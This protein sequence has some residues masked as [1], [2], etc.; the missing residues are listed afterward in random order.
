MARYTSSPSV[1]PPSV[2]ACAQSWLARG[3]NSRGTMTA[4]V[5]VSSQLAGTGKTSAGQSC[6]LKYQA[7]AAAE[8]SSQARKHCQFGKAPMTTRV[9]Q[10]APRSSRWPQ[11]R[12]LTIFRRP[13]WR[14]EKPKTR[15]IVRSAEARNLNWPSQNRTVVRRAAPGRLR[16]L[17]YASALA[18]LMRPLALRMHC[19]NARTTKRT[20]TNDSEPHR[21][22]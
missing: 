4:A 18:A 13:N 22:T 7:T 5:G 21:M 9:D 14:G 16:A 6:S 10:P 17:E 15:R 8:A 2:F 12:R 1:R 3:R 19:A 11:G 20:R